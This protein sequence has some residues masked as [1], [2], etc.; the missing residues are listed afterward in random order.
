M[1]AEI[2]QGTHPILEAALALAP[3]IRE[4]AREIEEGRRL[5]LDLVDAMKDAGIFGMAMPRAWGGPELDPLMQI[6]V[7]EALSEADGSVGWC[8]MI[9]SDGGYYSAFLE[10]QVARE[11]YRDREAPTGSSLVFAGRADKVDGGYRVKGRWPFVSGCQHSDW[12]AATCVV[13]ENGAQKMIAEGVPERRVGFVPA[14]ECEVLDTWHTTGLRGSGSNDVAIDDVF[15]PAERS[16]TFPFRPLRTE[17]LYVW[18]MMF[19]YNVPGVTLG[20]ARGAIDTFAELAA[21]K[22][23]TVSMVTGHPVMLRDEAYAQTAIARAET[24]LGAAR[25]YV[26]ESMKDLWRTLVEGERLSLKQRA[27]YRL[28]IAHAHTAC[29]EAVEGLYKALGG[30]SVYATGPFDRPLRDL[31]TINQHTVNSL[32]L[33]ETAG[34]ILLGYDL[35]DPFI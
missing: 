2:D 8:A 30:S 13:Y 27:V 10:D 4:S 31:I 7:I 23:T 29:L 3:R 1:T 18:P 15:V 33:Q 34:K 28:A 12:I 26:F 19:V 22:Q 17:P 25:A 5:P 24:L 6:R 32:K 14:A 35:R 16:A 11:M 21:R 9:N 20:I